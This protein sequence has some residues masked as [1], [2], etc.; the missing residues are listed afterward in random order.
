MTGC[1]NVNV[2]FVFDGMQEKGC[3]GLREAVEANLEWFEGTGLILSSNGAWLSDDHPC[4][5]YGMRG[6]ICLT[7]EVSGPAKDLHTGTDGGAFNEPMNDLVKLLSHLV[8]SNNMILVPGQHACHL[9][10][11]VATEAAECGR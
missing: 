4:L 5:I 3:V 6:L 9:E 2:V 11:D 8:D 10:D 7:V 1:L